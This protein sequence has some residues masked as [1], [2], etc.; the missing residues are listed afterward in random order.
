MKA[1]QETS[2]N[3]WNRVMVI[4]TTRD[5]NRKYD[6]LSVGEVASMMGKHPVDALLDLAL[7][8]DLLTELAFPCFVN[9]EPNATAE[10]LNHPGTHP[11]ISDGGAH[12]SFVQ[13]AFWPTDLLSTWVRDRGIMSLE[14]AH[15]KLSALPAWIAGYRDRGM[16]REGMAADIIVYDFDKLRV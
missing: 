7:D 8:E 2:H 3:N 5:R 12:F 1:V 6:G 13:M 9:S 11:A 16:L 4:K 14:K 15:Y 10:I